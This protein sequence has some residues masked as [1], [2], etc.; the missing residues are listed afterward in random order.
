[1]LTCTGEQR[2]DDSPIVD[3]GRVLL[4]LERAYA[5][6]GISRDER[7]CR[8]KMACQAFTVANAS[9]KQALVIST[10]IR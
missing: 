7:D 5:L 9:K 3:S 2:S 6:Y 8:V 1:M 4:E 10:A